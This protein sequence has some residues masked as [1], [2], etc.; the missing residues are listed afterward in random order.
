MTIYKILT[1]HKPLLETLN[2]LGITRTEEAYYTSIYQEYLEH[3]KKGDKVS[4]VT[5]K[6][7]EKY[8]L[9]QRTIYSIVKK[10]SREV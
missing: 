6:L 8:N 9:S 7:A 1:L 2:K 3:I 10:L 4:F 5:L